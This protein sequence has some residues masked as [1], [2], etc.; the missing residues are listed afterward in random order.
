MCLAKAYLTKFNDKP[1]LQD[2]A[3][4]KLFPDEVELETLFGEKRTVSG[5]VIE[6]DFTNSMILLDGKKESNELSRRRDVVN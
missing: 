3:R 2:I 5:K 6:I 4:M 1:L